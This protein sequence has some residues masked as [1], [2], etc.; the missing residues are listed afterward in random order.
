MV[1][2]IQ[3]LKQGRLQSENGDQ[4]CAVSV[5]HCV[6]MSALAE[7]LSEL[8]QLRVCVTAANGDVCLSVCHMGDCSYSFAVTF[9]CCCCLVLK[10]YSLVR[11]KYE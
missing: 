3:Y 9:L 1:C 4:Y 6:A 10:C 2:T 5:Q 11:G 8:C 7:F